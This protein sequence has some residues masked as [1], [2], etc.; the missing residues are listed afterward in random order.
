MAALVGVESGALPEGNSEPDARGG[1][2][3]LAVLLA[4]PPSMLGR[5]TTAATPRA[6]ITTT[7]IIVRKRLKKLS[8][9][10]SPPPWAPY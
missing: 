7:A 6:R 8:S 2:D 4:L 5:I 9:P 10:V 3:G 1:S